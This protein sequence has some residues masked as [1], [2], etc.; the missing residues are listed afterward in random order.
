MTFLA[1]LL[2]WGL[3]LVVLPIVIH[4]LNLR[5]HRL[6]EWGAMMFLL[7][8]TR[9]RRGHTRLRHLL[10]LATR[11]LAVAALIFVISR[12]LA[13]RWLGW[14]G[15]QPDTV[16]VL[17]DRSA[18]MAQQDL[19]SGQSKRSLAVEQIA[20]AIEHTRAPRQLVLIESGGRRPHPIGTPS[21]L[22]EIPETAAT[23]GAANIP[24]MLQQALDY[25]VAN[26]TGSTDIWICSDLQ[27]T[28]WSP[29]A[30]QWPALRSGFGELKQPLR[31]HLLTYPQRPSQ[32]LSVR[33]LKLQRRR[34]GETDQLV[35]DVEIRGEQVTESTRVPVGIVVD[36]ARSVVDVELTGETLRLVD[37]V[38]PLD[39][40]RA[41]GWGRIELP[42]DANP[43]DN[44][45]F[46]T[47]GDSIL[48]RAAIVS[49]EPGSIWPLRLAAAPPGLASAAVQVVAGSELQDLDWERTSLLLWQAALPDADQQARLRE[50]VDAGGTLLFFPPL[51]RSS[52]SF[53]GVRWV[54]WKKLTVSGQQAVAQ[55]N[56][57]SGLL[58]HSDAGEP[59]PV[60][61]L[62]V[63]DYCLL[64]GTAQPLARLAGGD[65]L[66]VH[67]PTDR[68]AV[69]FCATLPQEPYSNL[70]HEGVVF[71]VMVQRALRLG[72]QRALAAQFGEIG[73]AD[74]PSPPASWRSRDG[75]PESDLS[76]QHQHVAGVYQAGERLLA[77]N[78]PANED[79]TGTLNHDQLERLFSGLNYRI[80][81]DN[82]QQ[83]R[84]LVAEIWRLFAG[85]VVVALIAE[86]GLCL[87]D[88]RPA[89]R[90]T[91]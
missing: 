81:Q 71:Y 87:P 3:P 85:L 74:P 7:Q 17:L 2:L 9:Q 14:L 50:F 11:M 42:N 78:R 18:S 58:A 19:Q 86:A 51:E 20:S 41:A 60:S 67:R 49:D 27:A 69:Y 15:R 34:G 26:R 13:G 28:D 73:A 53:L 33:M 59:L 77:R 61:R 57:D 31:I 63:N 43:R 25:V 10:I 89:K 48:H 29:D 84:S 72:S 8:A 37:H 21:A 52:E 38:V 46:F 70:A 23:D 5:R 45:F 1:P 54:E 82:L 12:P 79:T 39:R 6:V 80:V 47:Y 62:E 91:T 64:Q 30:G 65:P 76:T 88:V 35:M 36:A 75:W 90:P 16:I 24:G 66:L 56:N 22:R 4:L 40:Q 83:G 44:V 55:W 68:G 32:N